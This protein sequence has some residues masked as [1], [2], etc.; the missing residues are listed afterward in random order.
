VL[1]TQNPIE[2]E[3]TYPLPE[4]QLDRFMF[5]ILVDYPS[6]EEEQLIVTQT[7]SGYA[8]ALEEVLDATQILALQR[9][10]RRVPVADEVVRYAVGLVRATRPSDQDSPQAVRRWV[11]WGA[12]PRASQYLILGAKTRAALNGRPTPE[13]ADVRAVAHPVLR[14]RI[15]TNYAAEAE[16]M[17][18]ESLVE[19]LL[20]EYGPAPF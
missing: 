12:G 16:G 20:E 2:Q 9:L 4:A 13:P 6:A 19:T 3:G 14:H 8:A 11:S 7:T 5:N 17:T 10:A 15:V 1:A 18:A